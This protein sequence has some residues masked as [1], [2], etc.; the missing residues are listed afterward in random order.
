MRPL[1]NILALVSVC[2][3][4]SCAEDETVSQAPGFVNKLTLGTGTN[5][6]NTALTGVETSFRGLG[7]VAVIYW[8]LESAADFNGDGVALKIEKQSG[9]TYT[10]ATPS[11]YGHRVVSSISVATSGRFRATGL[12]N[13]TS[14]EI[15][16]TLFTVQL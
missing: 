12:L 6:A 10:Y 5:A 3:L 8:Q 14:G 9:S 2:L 13:S 4:T 7:G 16:S 15:A 11:V 1:L